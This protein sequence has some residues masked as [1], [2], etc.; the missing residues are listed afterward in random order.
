[1]KFKTIFFFLVFLFIFYG[2]TV[3]S[4]DLSSERKSTEGP[5]ELALDDLINKIENRYATSGF[6]ARFFQTST[7]KAMEITDR[8][9]GEAVFKRPDKMRWV[10]EKPDRQTIITDGN[11]LW[12]F[13]PEDNQVMIGKAPSFFE[14]GKGF[15]F[16]S[17]MKLI[18]EKFSIYFEKKTA[19]DNV[20]LK[21]LP[22]EK[23]YDVSE[24]YLTILSST[25]EIV[26]V[27][28]Y[29]SYGDETQIEFK[30]IR[31]KRELDDSMFSFKIPQGVEVLHLEE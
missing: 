26:R 19:T 31:F 5:S 30:N 17:D 21:L 23:T 11:T 9:S 25:F 27:A 22:R 7:I 4:Q 24:I 6:S 13:R 8:A 28:T 2:Q 14:G 18:K 20:I 16:L 10:Y 1:M 15:S 29:N 12:V 3:L